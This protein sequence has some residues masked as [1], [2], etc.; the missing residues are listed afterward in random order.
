MALEIQQ[1]TRVGWETR[2]APLVV[3]GGAEVRSVA[4]WMVVVVTVFTI[5]GCFFGEACSL[6]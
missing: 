6:G 3:G 4:R 5:V 2:R 1:K